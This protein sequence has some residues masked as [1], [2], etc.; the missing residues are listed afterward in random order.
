VEQGNE[1]ELSI[2]R[3]GA[4]GDGVG[5]GAGRLRGLRAVDGAR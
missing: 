5:P 4:G 2:E 1:I 3:L